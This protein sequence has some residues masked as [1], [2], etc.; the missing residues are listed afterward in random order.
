MFCP[1]C[2]G[3]MEST[4]RKMSDIPLPGDYSADM[5]TWRCK[6]CKKTFQEVE[7]FY[8]GHVDLWCKPDTWSLGEVDD[9]EGE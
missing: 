4:P 6:K 9:E 3:K 7:A 1:F 5:R 8:C 2:G